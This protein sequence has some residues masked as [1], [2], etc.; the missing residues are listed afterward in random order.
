MR[1]C[2][3][4]LYHALVTT[5][6]LEVSAVPAGPAPGCH[7]HSPA[8]APVA[9]TPVYHDGPGRTGILPFQMLRPGCLQKLSANISFDG[10]TEKKKLLHD[11]L[12]VR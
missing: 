3:G 12:R 5:P 8:A 6:C 2:H 10:Q 11:E 1:G 9:A 4:Y 7:Y